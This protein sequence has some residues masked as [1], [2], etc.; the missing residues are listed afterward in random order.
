M[1]GGSTPGYV[2]G[3]IVAVSGWSIPRYYMVRGYTH[4][5]DYITVEPYRL[6]NCKRHGI[7]PM[8]IL[9]PCLG[10]VVSVIPRDSIVWRVPH[11]RQLELPGR[12]KRFLEE[13]K[14]F[15]GLDDLWVTG[16][17]AVA[18]EGYSSDV[19]II[20]LYDDN[21][22][23]TLRDLA[24]EGIVNQCQHERILMKRRVRGP[25]GAGLDR[26]KVDSSLLDS[27][28]RGVPYTLRL[29]STLWEEPCRNPLIPIGTVRVRVRI[30]SGSPYTVPARYRGEVVELIEGEQVSGEVTIESWRTR[31]QELSPGLY[32]VT[33]L[34]RIASRSGRIIIWPDMDGVIRSVEGDAW[35]D[36]L[37]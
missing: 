3:V 14:D 29:L 22:V 4:T 17:Y 36:N 21:V 15:L 20:A 27:C 8:H 16:S 31:Y 10:V 33:G 35:S 23:K 2:D 18:C 1:L 12:I 7:E 19:D 9:H 13:F 34:A 30:T 32:E 6:F 24:S 11:G 26:V 28:F 25:A 5:E 37:Y